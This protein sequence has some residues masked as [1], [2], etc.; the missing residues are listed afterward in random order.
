M[1]AAKHWLRTD[2]PPTTSFGFCGGFCALMGNKPS[3]AADKQV[4]QRASQ[5]DAG[6]QDE[7]AL[8]AGTLGTLHPARSMR[9]VHGGKTHG[10]DLVKQTDRSSGGHRGRTHELLH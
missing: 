6:G 8:A 4:G 2:R 10:W 3:C 9:A 5:G 7:H 1:A